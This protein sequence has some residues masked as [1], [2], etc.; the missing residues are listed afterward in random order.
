MAFVSFFHT[1]LGWILHSPVVWLWIG[2][3]NI[4]FND[5]DIG[6]AKVNVK[7]RCE[8]T[9]ILFHRAFVGNSWS[10]YRKNVTQIKRWKQESVDILYVRRSKVGFVM[11]HKVFLAPRPTPCVIVSVEQGYKNTHIKG[12]M[13]DS[14]WSS[15]QLRV[16]SVNSGIFL[17]RKRLLY[18][19]PLWNPF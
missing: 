8:K 15:S 19:P 13:C 11:F 12:W 1:G 6:H 7:A 3:K 10:N 4:Y 14:N 16:S 2:K 18:W 17:K 9:Q 5:L